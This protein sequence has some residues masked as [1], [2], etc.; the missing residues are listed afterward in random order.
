MVIISSPT[1]YFFLYPTPLGDVLWSVGLG[2]DRM[3]D[4]IVYT[5]R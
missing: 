3:I 1:N 5:R 2:E 4:A